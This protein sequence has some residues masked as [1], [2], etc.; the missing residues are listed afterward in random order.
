MVRCS[1]LPYHNL[2]V[3]LFDLVGNKRRQRNYSEIEKKWYG[4]RKKE[5]EE[6]SVRIGGGGEWV[7]SFIL[8]VGLEDSITRTTTATTLS[9][10]I[11]LLS[12]THYFC[13]LETEELRKSSGW[14]F[15]WGDPLRCYNESYCIA[16]GSTTLCSFDGTHWSGMLCVWILGG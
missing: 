13:C 5:E 6:H 11:P 7:G 10:T 16:S 2:C 9:N 3:S 15:N 1:L 12:P 8:W 14:N 4:D